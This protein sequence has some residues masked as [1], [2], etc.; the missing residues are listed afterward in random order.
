[1][2][3]LQCGSALKTEK[4][5]INK[6]LKKIKKNLTGARTFKN[7][8]ALGVTLKLLL[9]LSVTF[10]RP[11]PCEHLGFDFTERW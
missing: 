4:K 6:N 10:T 1:M 3:S 7:L 5:E 8:H 9:S 2:I 11:G